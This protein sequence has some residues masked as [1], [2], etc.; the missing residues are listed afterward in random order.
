MNIYEE[1]KEKSMKRISIW[2]FTA[3]LAGAVAGEAVR[4]AQE[5]IRGRVQIQSINA[6]DIVTAVFIENDI[7]RYIVADTPEGRKLFKLIGTDV[8]IQGITG[9]DQEG[10]PTLE[11]ESFKIVND[12]E[13]DTDSQSQ[14]N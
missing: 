4:A 10:A 1:V 7:D 3:V 2:L 5:V 6:D 14:S 9:R 13:I 8:I 11:V 12:A